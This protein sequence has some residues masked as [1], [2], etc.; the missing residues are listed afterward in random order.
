MKWQAM[1]TALAIAALGCEDLPDCPGADVCGRNDSV[2]NKNQCACSC[3]AP[4]EV[5]PAHMCCEDAPECAESEE[6]PDAE[7]GMTP[8]AVPRVHLDGLNLFDGNDN[9]IDACEPFRAFFAY[10]NKMNAPLAAPNEYGLGEPMLSITEVGLGTTTPPPPR[11]VP[12]VTGLASAASDPHN[13]EYD[14]GIQPN[15]MNQSGTFA[16]TISPLPET[17]SG[18]STLGKDIGFF[19][20]ECI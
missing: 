19:G 15:N 17:A 13:E 9:F 14:D 4:Q 18:V 1:A 6:T 10:V 3:T 20:S 16:V 11:A 7:G 8:A 12:W 2:L 5:E